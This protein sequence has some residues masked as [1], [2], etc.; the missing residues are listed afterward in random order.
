[1]VKKASTPKKRMRETLSVP[2]K[3]L[4]KILKACANRSRLA[5][6]QYLKKN[7]EAPVGEIARHINLSFKATSKH[8]SILAGVDIVDR[9]QRSL[10]IYYS[11]NRQ[12]HP[13]LKNILSL[14]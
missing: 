2:V 9:D 6:I 3:Q 14:L 12:S 4:E 1:M 11:L 8:L 7:D 13:L 5:I 10:Q